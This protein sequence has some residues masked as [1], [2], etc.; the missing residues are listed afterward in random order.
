M[1]AA[2]RRWGKNTLAEGQIILPALQGKPV[3][4]FSPTYKTLAEDWRRRPK[5]ASFYLTK[6]GAAS[7][8]SEVT[9]LP[10][11]CSSIGASARGMHERL[12]GI[13]TPAV[14]GTSSR[15]LQGSAT[16]PAAE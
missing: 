11:E 14:S 10:L 4:W 16:R 12:F 9:P 8:F 6:L 13:P 7:Q 1:I 15:P 5:R 2:G 3:A